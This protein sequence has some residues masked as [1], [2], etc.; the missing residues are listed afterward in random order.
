[1]ELPF[2]CS[3]WLN[4]ENIQ[5]EGRKILPQ[6]L[7]IEPIM[8]NYRTIFEVHNPALILAA[9]RSRMRLDQYLSTLFNLAYSREYA[10][11]DLCCSKF[12]G[13]PEVVIPGIGRVDVLTADKIIEVKDIRLW[14]GAIGQI[15]VYSQFYPNHQPTIA[16]TPNPKNRYEIGTIKQICEKLGIEVI[17]L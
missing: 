5:T 12:N 13:T 3:I 7:D 10:Y 1:M 16:L 9:K 4:S 17:E 14:K 15:L 2:K 11:R 6:I 8:G